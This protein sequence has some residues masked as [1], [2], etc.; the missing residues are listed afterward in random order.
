MRLL[1]RTQGMEIQ[2]DLGWMN[3][4]LSPNFTPLGWLE[5]HL[6]AM[7]SAPSEHH[8]QASPAQCHI[9]CL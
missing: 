2:R 3:C 9:S 5:E 6:V 8:T 1:Y 7:S 4:V